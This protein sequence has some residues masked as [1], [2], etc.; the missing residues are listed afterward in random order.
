MTPLAYIPL[1]FMKTNLTDI[2]ERRVPDLV[3]H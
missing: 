3:D 1:T 2:Y